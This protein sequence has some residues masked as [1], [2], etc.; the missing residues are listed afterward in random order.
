MP[1]RAVV[2]EQFGEPVEVLDV[3]EVA[4]PE[5]GP[6]QVRLRMLASPV[7]PSDLLT[8]RG[9]YGRLPHLPATPGFEGVGVVDAAGPGLL[10]WLRRLSPGKKV[11]A[12][13]AAGGNW[14]EYVV[15]PAQQVVPVGDLA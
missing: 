11:A 5:P 15:L 13:N 4:K 6:G 12:L 9:L 10:R 2:F 1:V 14:Q 7:N 8:V 3:R